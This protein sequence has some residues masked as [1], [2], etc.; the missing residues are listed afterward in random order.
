MKQIELDPALAQAQATPPPNPEPSLTLEAE[1]P[2]IAG[3]TLSGEDEVI[4][5]E[6]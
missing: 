4:T 3:E 5:V 2:D 6:N 1:P